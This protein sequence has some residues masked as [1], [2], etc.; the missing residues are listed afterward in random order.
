VRFAG[1][2]PQKVHK[3]DLKTRKTELILDEVIYLDLSFNGEKML[4]GKRNQL[5]RSSGSSPRQRNRPKGPASQARA[6][7][8]TWIP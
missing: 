6:V 3:F 8:S 2:V 4:Y 7:C 1:S 5:S